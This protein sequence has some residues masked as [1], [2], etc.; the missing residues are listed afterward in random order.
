[1]REHKQ[2]INLCLCIHSLV[3]LADQEDIINEAIDFF[4]ANVLFRNFKCEGPADLLLCYLTIYISENIRFMQKYKTK[5]EAYKNITSLSMSG[6]FA[7]PGDKGFP[8]PGFFK[9]ASSRSD[10]GKSWVLRSSQR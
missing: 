2:R 6:N 5:K 9:E 8:L 4:R 10:A 3:M 1:M 7:I